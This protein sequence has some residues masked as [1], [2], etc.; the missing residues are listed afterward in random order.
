ME[1]RP[2]GGGKAE[3]DEYPAAEEEQEQGRRS[4]GRQKEACE[5]VSLVLRARATPSGRYE[6]GRACSARPASPNSFTTSC[7][8]PKQQQTIVRITA[9]TH[10]LSAYGPWDQPKARTATVVAAMAAM[11]RACSFWASESRSRVPLE[12]AERRSSS[13]WRLM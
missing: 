12:A 5:P 13:Q 2:T 7:A 11:R 1:G 4:E 10:P 6:P 3:E 9:W 8:L